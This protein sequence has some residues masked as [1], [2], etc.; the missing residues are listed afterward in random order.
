VKQTF[1][2]AH[3]T[4]RRNAIKAVEAA[5]AGHMVQISEPTKKREQEE[6]YHAMVGDIARQAEH[7]GRKWDAD[8]MKRLLVD[9]FAE[10]M[11]LAG[12]PLHHDSRVVPSFDGKRIV[13]MGIQTR[14]FYVKEASQFIEFLFAWG[15]DRGVRWS[16][17]VGR[18]ME[19]SQ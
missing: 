9:E 11:R 13:Q 19:P 15:A 12:T 17:P 3:D 2:M 5:P 16:D 10:E 7:I 8:D 14:D 6:R 1:I 18:E 4:A